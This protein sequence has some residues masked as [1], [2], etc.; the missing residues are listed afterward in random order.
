MVHLVVGA[1]YRWNMITGYVGLY[2]NTNNQ[3]PIGAPLSML[4]AGLT[5]RLGFKL[6][7]NYGSRW[8]MAIGVVISTLSVVI[9]S[10]MT[11]FWGTFRIIKH[12][13][14]FI[15]SSSV[16]ALAFSSYPLSRSAISSFLSLNQSP[17]P[18]SSQGLDLERCSLVL[19]ISNVFRSKT[20]H[21]KWTTISC[22]NLF[23][24]ILLSASSKW[25]S[26]CS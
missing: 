14:S 2:Y 21:I 16:S 10:T 11:T 3:T 5:M 7:N 17:I 6:S 13:S 18:S 15:T 8:V 9:G 24:D 19:T 23:K 26:Q 12:L 20:K 1:I 4:C 22:R 25:P